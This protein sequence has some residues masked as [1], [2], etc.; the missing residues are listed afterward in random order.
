IAPRSRKVFAYNTA[1]SF[2]RARSV[3]RYLTAALHLPP[4]KLYLSGSGEKSPL[5]T[6]RTEAG[7]SL[8][9][10]VEVN[11]SATQTIETNHLK[12]IKERSG[13]QKQETTSGSVRQPVENHPALASPQLKNET[14]EVKPASNRSESDTSEDAI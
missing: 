6:N 12:I 2:A 3:G 10:R 5:A 4:E 13:L 8:N 14:F 1:L 7:R 9:R 11:I